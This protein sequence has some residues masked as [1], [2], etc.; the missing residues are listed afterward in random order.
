MLFGLQGTAAAAGG[1]WLATGEAPGVLRWAAAVQGKASPAGWK[2]RLGKMGGVPWLPSA[3]GGAADG[4]CGLD[5]GSDASVESTEAFDG[6]PERIWAAGGKSGGR[7][8]AR[9]VL[10]WGLLG[11]MVR[12]GGCGVESCRGWVAARER[13]GGMARWVEGGD[14]RRLLERWYAGR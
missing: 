4:E 7:W 3:G 6:L 5:G 8:M 1:E 9:P 2:Q 10:P 12:S 14:G 13:D 11:G